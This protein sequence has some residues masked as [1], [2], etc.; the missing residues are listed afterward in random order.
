MVGGGSGGVGGGRKVDPGCEAGTGC[1]VGPRGAVFESNGGS[2]GVRNLGT[3]SG[4][5]V[6]SCLFLSTV[7][8]SVSFLF[9]APNRLV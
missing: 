1:E 3:V 5:A 6:T 4:H 8:R 2:G 7:R 9:F